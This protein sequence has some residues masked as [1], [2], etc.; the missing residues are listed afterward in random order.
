[1]SVEYT[2]FLHPK[3]YTMLLK[4]NGDRCFRGFS[5]PSV[6]VVTLMTDD[7]MSDTKN[8]TA[9]QVAQVATQPSIDEARRAMTLDALLALL[10]EL[11]LRHPLQGDTQIMVDVKGADLKL[12][13]HVIDAVPF[14]P[15]AFTLPPKP[16][17]LLVATKL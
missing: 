11:K 10:G 5:Q 7:F 14:Y 6:T 2:T 1:M 13:G 9:A 4:H 16:V 8:E 12:E 15:A 17:V 3:A